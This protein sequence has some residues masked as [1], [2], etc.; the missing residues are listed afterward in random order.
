MN[1]TSIG[2]W[3]IAFVLTILVALYLNAA[4]SKALNDTFDNLP[5]RDRAALNVKVGSHDD[6][7]NT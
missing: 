6:G 4:L 7:V 3:L 5:N 1:R 2:I